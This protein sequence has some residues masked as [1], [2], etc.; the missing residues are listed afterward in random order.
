[1]AA[2]YT[3]NRSTLPAVPDLARLNASEI[4][5][6]IKEDPAHLVYQVD[7]DSAEEDGQVLEL[8]SVGAD[9]PQVLREAVG[10]DGVNAPGWN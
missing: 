4:A 10:F 5:A 3:I 2:L 9:C 6:V 7:E 8:L 1:M